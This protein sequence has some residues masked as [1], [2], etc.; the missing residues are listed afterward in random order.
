MLMLFKIQVQIH[1]L[2]ACGCKYLCNVF[3]HNIWAL[4]YLKVNGNCMHLLMQVESQGLRNEWP[5][6]NGTSIELEVEF[7]CG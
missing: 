3:S 4:D 1:N 5:N 7:T 6:K 2:F